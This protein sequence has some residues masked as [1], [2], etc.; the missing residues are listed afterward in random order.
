MMITAALRAGGACGFIA[1]SVLSASLALDTAW[2]VRDL[3]VPRFT[4]ARGSR[5][6]RGLRAGG[7]LARHGTGTREGNEP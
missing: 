3:C 6:C 7:T 5:A 1:A 2:S 4:A